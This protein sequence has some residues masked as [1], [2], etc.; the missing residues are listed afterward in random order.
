MSATPVDDHTE[1]FEQ[2]A[3]L[4]ALDVLEGD[5]RSRFQAHVARCERCQVIVRLDREALRH[6]SSTAPEMD[7]SPDFKDRLMHRA[8]EELRRR[9][10]VPLRADQPANV[11]PLWRRRPWLSAIAAV[12]VLGVATL[13]GVAYEN[14]VVATYALSGNAPGAATVLV[15]RSGTAELQMNGAP[16]PGQGFVYEAWIIP[17]GGQPVA[18]GA[19]PS[20]QGSVALSGDV[21]GNT[22]AITRELPGATAP[23]S[24]PLMAT[25]VGT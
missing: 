5:D 22:V 4:S 17:P 8:A 9:E 25:E 15:R 6:L 19:L 18:A 7:P 21:R 2:L 24:T 3:G 23:T 1:E 11:I 13:A 20:G 10:P 12:L 16:D 14:Q